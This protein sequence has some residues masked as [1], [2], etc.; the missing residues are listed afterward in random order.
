MNDSSNNKRFD[1]LEFYVG[2]AKQAA[3]YYSSCF[4]F[5]NTAYCGLETGERKGEHLSLAL[6][7][8]T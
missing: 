3:H 1:H 2:N 6:S 7:I 4:G 5:K 8:N